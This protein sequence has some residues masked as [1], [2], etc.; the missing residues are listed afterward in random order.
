MNK[1]AKS[2]VNKKYTVKSARIAESSRIPKGAYC[3]IDT[4]R[5]DL[6][7]EEIAR[8]IITSLKW[9]DRYLRGEVK[10]HRADDGW[11]D[12]LKRYAEEE[13]KNGRHPGRRGK[14]RGVRNNR[15]I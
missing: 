3:S 5:Y 12:E 14:Y 6:T 11:L 13:T 8:D 4:S 7:E 9:T 1:D 15:T 2:R 10:A